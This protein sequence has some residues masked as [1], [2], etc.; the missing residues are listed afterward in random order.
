M[1][2]LIEVPNPGHIDQGRNF[3]F[4]ENLVLIIHHTL[5]SM[6]MKKMYSYLMLAAILLAFTP[7]S[8]AQKEKL[9][10]KSTAESKGYKSL[11]SGEAII[12][13]KYLHYAHSPKEADKYANKYFFSTSNSETLQSLTKYNLKKAFPE[14]HPFH[15][16]LDANFKEDKELINYDDFHKMYKV[17]WLMKQHP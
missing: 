4:L 6:T 2:K 14:N 10:P 3:L 7:S 11:N 13:Y 8:N 9:I 17:N 16:A 1:I 15:D 5:N 12:I